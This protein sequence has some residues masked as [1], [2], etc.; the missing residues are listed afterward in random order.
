[1]VIWGVWRS[2][3]SGVAL[4]TLSDLRSHSHGSLFQRWV[5]LGWLCYSGRGFPQGQTHQTIDLAKK[6]GKFFY[7]QFEL[8]RL[9]LSFF[10]HSPLR[11]FLRHTSHCNQRSST[12]SKEARTVSE[13]AQAASKKAP[14]HNCRQRSSAVSRKLPTVR[15]KAASK[16]KVG[17]ECVFSSIA[18]NG[19]KVGQ[20]WVS[21]PCFSQ[22]RSLLTHFWA[23]SGRWRRTHF[24]PIFAP[25][26]S[27]I[28]TNIFAIQKRILRGINL[29]NITKNIFQ[30]WSRIWPLLFAFCATSTP[31]RIPVK[32]KYKKTGRGIDLQKFRGEWYWRSWRWRA[33]CPLQEKLL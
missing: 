25:K 8:F 15:K 6:R 19:P 32:K 22:N 3:Q 29:V 1:M 13:K 17:Q 11:C 2:S 20:K 18:R 27:T 26:S 9:Q 30:C 16:K 7:L 14:K 10:A 31:Q 5:M 24:W 33:P 21:G 23:I 28:N 12:V 4:T